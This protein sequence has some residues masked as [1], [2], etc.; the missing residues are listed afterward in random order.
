[1]LAISSYNIQKLFFSLDSTLRKPRS[2]FFLAWDLS[3][4]NPLGGTT[5][6]TDTEDSLGLGDGPCSST[7]EMPKG[8][9]ITQ[10]VSVWNRFTM[11]F[12]NS[13]LSLKSLLIFS[14]L[15]FLTYAFSSAVS[16][17]NDKRVSIKS[18]DAIKH[19]QIF[20]AKLMLRQL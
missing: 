2:Q 3:P 1:M 4:H 10:Q 14:T 5:F 15:L 6:L 18:N 20:S 9:N 17:Y 11:R 8:F 13:Q 16:K 19:L 7:C 12:P